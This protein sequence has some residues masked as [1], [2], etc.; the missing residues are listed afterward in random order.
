MFKGNANA[1][2]FSINWQPLA[3][4]L[5]LYIVISGNFKTMSYDWEQGS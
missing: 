4:F 2:I 1:V 3:R 5:D